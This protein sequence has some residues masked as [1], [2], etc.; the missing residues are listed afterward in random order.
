[1]CTDSNLGW[2]CRSQVWFVLHRHRGR[3]RRFFPLFWRNLAH[4]DQRAAVCP[5]G[6]KALAIPR[7]VST[8]VSLGPRVPVQ[9]CLMHLSWV[10]FPSTSSFSSLCLSFRKFIIVLKLCLGA[11]KGNFTLLKCKGRE[12][13]TCCYPQASCVSVILCLESMLIKYMA[14]AFFFVRSLSHRM[15]SKLAGGWQGTQLVTNPP[16][17]PLSKWLVKV[18]NFTV[19]DLN[20]AQEEE[21]LRK[22]MP[23]WIENYVFSIFCQIIST[24]AHSALV[25]EQTPCQGVTQQIP[26]QRTCAGGRRVCRGLW[27][28]QSTCL[29]QFTSGWVAPPTKHGHVRLWR[30]AMG[31][32]RAGLLLRAQSQGNTCWQPP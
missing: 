9:G 23:L 18:I 3:I 22:P 32:H 2:T 13:V 4:F 21:K 28:W 26:A 8:Q 29:Q 14:G 6:S 31:K 7:A 30:V 11:V 19:I 24:R 12:L 10:L 16:A 25:A 15:F 1:M 20:V 17:H 27:L 5:T